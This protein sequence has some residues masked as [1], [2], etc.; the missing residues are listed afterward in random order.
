MVS[1][2]DD[3]MGTFYAM[4]KGRVEIKAMNLAGYDIVTPGNHEFD[5]DVKT[6]LD[7]ISS[8]HFEIVS[9]NLSIKNE[10]LKSLI[11]PFVI[12]NMD[13]IRI[14]VFGL[15]TPDLKRFPILETK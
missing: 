13:G 10:K 11:K 14:G 8:A 15:M 6:Y 9:S 5:Q 12:K 4:F 3:L 1:T 2:G 7:A